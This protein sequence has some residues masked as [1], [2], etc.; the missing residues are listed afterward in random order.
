MMEK[1]SVLI[2]LRNY[3]QESEW[4]EARSDDDITTIQR[5]DTHTVLI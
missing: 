4:E 1:I 2:F 5:K 3:T